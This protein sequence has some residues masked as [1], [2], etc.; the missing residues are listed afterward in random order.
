MKIVGKESI[1]GNIRR[2]I[3]Q[4]ISELLESSKKNGTVCKSRGD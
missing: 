4:T 1:L 3:T 2:E